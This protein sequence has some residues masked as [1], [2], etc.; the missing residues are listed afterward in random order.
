MFDSVSENIE[1]P[2]AAAPAKPGTS[3]AG[4]E[5]PD[6]FSS[7]GH[8]TRQLHDSLHELGHDKALGDA[9]RT[10]PDA[11][12][13]LTYIV[14]MTEQAATRALNA[15][16]VAKPIQDK[17]E[18][19]SLALGTRWE[20]VF[21]NQLSAADFKA[22]ATDTHAFCVQCHNVAG[23]QRPVEEIM[24]AQDFQDLTGQVIRWWIWSGIWRPKC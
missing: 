8:M 21:A 2:A 9:A 22:L 6:V 15:I 5:A 19:Q 20:K 11:R 14:H 3:A 16:E 4:G 7:L 12:Q 18:S 13:R 10:I 23:D 17:L 24:M 1:I